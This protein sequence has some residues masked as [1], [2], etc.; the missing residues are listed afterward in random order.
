MTQKVGDSGSIYNPNGSITLYAKWQANI[1][2]VVLNNQSATTA[3]STSVTATYGNS[4][5]EITIPER[6]YTVTYNTNGGGTNSSSDIATYAF[7]GYYTANGG[8]GTQYYTSSGASAKNWDLISNTTLYAKWVEGTGDVTLPEDMS[9]AGYTFDGWYTSASGGT[10]VGNEGDHY[11]PTSNI[12]L[13]A[14]W[15]INKVN[16]Q[17]HMN[18]GTWGGSTN[19]SL[20]YSGSLV[21]LNGSTIISSYDYGTTGIDLANWDNANYINI[22][23]SGYYVKTGAEWKLSN[24]TIFSDTGSVV[25][26]ASLCD[27]SISSCTATL[28]VNWI[29]DTVTAV[30]LASGPTKTHYYSS[31]SFSSAGIKLKLT[32]ASGKTATVNGASYVTGTTTNTNN[33]S[34]VRYTTTVK[35]GSFSAFTITTYKKGWYGI[36]YGYFYYYS[37]N[38]TKTVGDAYLPIDNGSSI[39]KYFHFLSDGTMYTGWRNDNSRYRYYLETHK[40]TIGVTGYVNSDSDVWAGLSG[41]GFTRG[42]KLTDAWAYIYDSSRSKYYWYRLGTDG[43][44]KTGW[45]QLSSK[46]YYART[47][48]NQCTSGPLGALITSATCN[49]GGSNYTFNADGACTSGSGC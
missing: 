31:E 18:G 16:V 20:G 35:Y 19:T 17:Y 47:S 26:S 4:M 24:G 49:I 39:Y 43:W 10:K 36:A 5:P 3:G 37:N 48:A 29:A 25:N 30:A 27:A 40:N 23:R 8:G 44:M 41:N 12:T 13:Y 11:R 7:G 34:G 15:T 9:R 21:T 32:Y 45:F 1:Y 46:W 42:A 6:K 38:G 14:H 22:T 33:A 28:Y 2:T